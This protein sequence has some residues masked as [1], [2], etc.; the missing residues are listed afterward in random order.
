M[1]S[2][3]DITSGSRFVGTRTAVRTVANAPLYPIN[4]GPVSTN[5]GGDPRNRRARRADRAK[6]RKP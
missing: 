3:E 1:R 4:L 5:D 6:K 2:D